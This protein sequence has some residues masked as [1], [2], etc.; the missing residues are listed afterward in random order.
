M[1]S[2]TSRT[3]GHRELSTAKARLQSPF[4]LYF[5]YILF[6]FVK[7]DSYPDLW[8]HGTVEGGRCLLHPEERAPRGPSGVVFQRPFL[9]VHIP[10]GCRL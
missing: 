7:G 1:E 2:P 3:C 6:R 8:A 4:M 5:R 9:K 10:S